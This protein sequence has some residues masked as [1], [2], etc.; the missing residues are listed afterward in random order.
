MARRG[1]VALFASLA[2]AV[3][4]L[5]AAARAETRTFLNSTD[6]F[7]IGDVNGTVGPANEYPSTIAVSGVP[8]TVTKAT[9][10]VL[11]LE[12]GNG[13]DIDMAIAGPNGQKVMLMS[14]ACGALFSNNDWTFDDAAGTFLSDNGPCS[15]SQEASFKPSNYGDP[16]QDDLSP[17]G[18]PA[19]PYLNSLS[20]LAGGSPNGAWN[21]FVRDDNATVFGFGIDAWALTL[22][23]KPPAAPPAATPVA[24]PV[25]TPPAA[26]QSGAGKKC[27]R[28][29]G[30]KPSAAAAK[31]C[32]KKKK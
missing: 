21:L 8:G 18:G 20:R 9:V 25:A 5:P 31:K 6:L 19:G 29:K 16:T 27:K 26:G 2:V 10:T 12:S 15:S 30:K 28:K 13:D 23:V 17:G 1:A 22:D 14:D 32:K 11:N 24:T 4:L 3:A 7:A